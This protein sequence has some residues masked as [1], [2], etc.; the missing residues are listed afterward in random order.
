MNKVHA[1]TTRFV[2]EERLEDVDA[3]AGD[4]LN[5]LFVILAWNPP[6]VHADDAPRLEFMLKDLLNFQVSGYG[7]LSAAKFSD[8]FK[9]FEHWLRRHMLEQSNVLCSSAAVDVLEF[10]R[11]HTEGT[12]LRATNGEVAELP[13]VVRQIP[14]ARQPSFWYRDSSVIKQQLSSRVSRMLVTVEVPEGEFLE[15]G[16]RRRVLDGPRQILFGI[17]CGHLTVARWPESGLF[18][19]GSPIKFDICDDFQF[20]GKF[21][22]KRGTPIL[23]TRDIMEDSFLGPSDVIPECPILMPGLVPGRWIR[24]SLSIGKDALCAAT[25]IEWSRPRAVH[26]KL[27]RITR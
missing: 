2:P 1:I 12:L 15:D 3:N 11:R 5:Y 13:S 25:P 4:V 6:Y 10:I 23:S 26:R 19:G 27:S 22:L 18:A 20:P 14:R 9:F 21:M 8:A 7:S 16:V 24:T 17:D